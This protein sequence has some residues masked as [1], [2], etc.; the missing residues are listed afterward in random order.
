[1]GWESGLTLCRALRMYH[2]NLFIAICSVVDAEEYRQAATEHGADYYLPKPLTSR[3]VDKLVHAFRASSRIR[4][5]GEDSRDW[6]QD[7]MTTFFEKPDR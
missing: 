2:P 1:L 4:T 3:D 7:L 5:Q 6:V